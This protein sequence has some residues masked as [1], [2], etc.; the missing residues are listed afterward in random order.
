VKFHGWN[1]V[2]RYRRAAER[3]DDG[4]EAG[5]GVDRAQRPVPVVARQIQRAGAIEGQA[6]ASGGD[7]GVSD[8]RSR[9]RREVDRDQ[10]VGAFRP[11]KQRPVRA[12]GNVG[13]AARA[14]ADGPNERA[15]TC[16]SI[17]ANQ[18]PRENIGWGLSRDTVQLTGDRVKRQTGDA[19]SDVPTTRTS[20][21][22]GSMIYSGLSA[23]ETAP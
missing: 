14:Q 8:N 23:P 17:D 3:S 7:A 6:A 12:K 22:V 2:G 11:A 1:R 18:I 19:E 15:G 4:R 9:S 10:V 5:R 16:S 21:V 13:N 20:R